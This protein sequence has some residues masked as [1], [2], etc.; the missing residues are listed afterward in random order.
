[1]TRYKKN[2]FGLDIVGFGGA[3][4]DGVGEDRGGGTS[5]IVSPIMY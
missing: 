3:E 2:E 1:M 5:G 4:G